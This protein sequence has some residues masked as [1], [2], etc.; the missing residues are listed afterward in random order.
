MKLEMKMYREKMKWTSGW[1]KSNTPKADSQT[2]KADRL[3]VG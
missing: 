3:N 2:I 1:K